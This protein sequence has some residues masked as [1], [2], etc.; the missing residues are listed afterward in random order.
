MAFWAAVQFL[1]VFPGRK[2]NVSSQALARAQIF[3][4]LVGL[5]LGLGLA[6]LDSLFSYLWPPA[7]VN[8][9]LVTCL[10]IA[11]G[12]LHLEGF[13]DSCDGLF[14]GSTRER[15]LEIMRDKHVGAFAVSGGSLLILLKWV[16]LLSLSP[17]ERFSL[18]VLFPA[19]SRWSMVLVIYAFPYAR[20]E[21]LGTDFH[22][23]TTGQRVLI[24]GG[25]TLGGV[26]VFAGLQGLV[27]L[28]VASGLAWLIGLLMSKRLGGLTGDTYGAINEIIEVTTLLLASAVFRKF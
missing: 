12:A 13:L 6:G 26:S 10:V 20:T 7:V 17:P 19:L 3:F 1:T 8:A 5:L 24:S 14:G 18:L 9:L 4:P 21:G 22:R 28:V 27:F 2:K 11:T 23:G 16:T 25:I 15:R